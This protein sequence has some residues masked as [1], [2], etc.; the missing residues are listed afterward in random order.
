MM[1]YYMPVKVVVE[2]DA[3]RN[4]ASAIA[5][6][7]TSPIGMIYTVVICNV[8]NLLIR[9]VEEKRNEAL[10]LKQTANL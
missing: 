8:I 5:G 9:V 7:G 4:G 10:L 2:K 1:N 6:C 3:V